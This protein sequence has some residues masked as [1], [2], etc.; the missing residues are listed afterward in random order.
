MNADATS[1]ENEHNLEIRTTGILSG[2][3]FSLPARQLVP[4]LVIAGLA[5]DGIT[6]VNWP[7]NCVDIF[8]HF[9]EKIQMLG[10]Q[11]EVTE[12]IAA[13]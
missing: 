13:E 10:G 6:I 3:E 2:A 7:K 9:V 11:I 8:D 4:G 1:D 12:S 5:A